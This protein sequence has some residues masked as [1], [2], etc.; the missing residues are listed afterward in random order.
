[1]N[2]KVNIITALT[3]TIILGFTGCGKHVQ[4][5]GVE[6]EQAV[7]AAEQAEAEAEEVAPPPA[8]PVSANSVGT[9]TDP[10]DGQTYRTV[11]IRN[12][13][14]MAENLNFATDSS[15][16]YGKDESNCQKY[17]RFYNWNSA[18]KACPS[19]W[20]LS[21]YE[22]WRNLVDFVSID[23]AGTNAATRLKST[24]GWDDR[25]ENNGTDVFGFSA[26]PGGGSAE[27]GYWWSVT[28]NKNDTGDEDGTTTWAQWSMYGEFRRVN[29]FR[30]VDDVNNSSFYESHALSVRCVAETE[31]AGGYDEKGG[32]EPVSVFGSDTSGTFTDSRDGQRYRMVTIDSQTWMAQNLNYATDSSWCY[33]D[34]NLICQ[35]YGRLY[36]WSMAMTA[37][38]SG[39]RLPTGDDWEKL[40][41]FVSADYCDDN[42]YAFF[43]P[44][45]TATARQLKSTTGWDDVFYIGHGTDD[46]GFS[47]IPG[48]VRWWDCGDDSDDG[49]IGSA[50]FQDAGSHSYWWGVVDDN[51]SFARIILLGNDGGEIQRFFWISKYEADEDDYWITWVEN[52]A[53]SIR[54]IKE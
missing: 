10:R 27:S 4:N 25:D 29:S 36:D 24:T 23:G 30:A 38:P 33:N 18:I 6:T 20:R 52:R 40:S 53:L 31:Q 17:G 51:V 21:T 54:C 46:F 48:G 42:S 8:D 5:P 47:A 49:C 3:A 2:R 11:R 13:T 45:S 37:C 43:Q 32:F 50:R 28:K 41:N 19:G 26:I 1:M 39:W 34:N 7:I 12:L 44:K 16:C 14:W 15:W 9:F 35:R 22:D